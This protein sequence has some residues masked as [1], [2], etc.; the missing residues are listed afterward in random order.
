MEWEGDSTPL[1]PSHVGLEN[2]WEMKCITA[3]PYRDPL[4][5]NRSPNITVQL[6]NLSFLENMVAKRTKKDPL[7]DIQTCFFWVLS[8]KV[9]DPQT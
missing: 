5:Q 4:L 9:H 1:L 2:K 8:G 7:K 6:Y 3:S